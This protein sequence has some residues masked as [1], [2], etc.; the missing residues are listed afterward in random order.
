MSKKHFVGQ[1]INTLQSNVPL[2]IVSK[3][4]TLNI[5]APLSFKILYL[6]QSAN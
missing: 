5:S 3:L 1:V 4:Q 6:T 2:K